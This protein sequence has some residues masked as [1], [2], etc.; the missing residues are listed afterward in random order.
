MSLSVRI[1]VC[2]VMISVMGKAANAQEVILTSK[3]KDAYLGVNGGVF[4][5]KP[6]VQSDLY[7]G[8]SNG[9][10]A[11]V[12]VSSGF[13]GDRDFDKEIDLTVGVNGS[14]AGIDYTIEA[15]Y[16]VLIVPD[17]FNIVVEGRKFLTIGHGVPIVPFLRLEGYAPF[18]DDGPR[19]GMMAI[20][21]ARCPV[22]IT[23]WLSGSLKAQ[24]RKD[25]GCFGNDPAVL[26]QGSL[27]FEARVSDD[28]NLLVGVTFSD[29]LT[30][31]SAADGRTSS[32]AL[33]GG[34]SYSF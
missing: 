23:P 20:I 1:L 15:S 9:V 26:A 25:T 14:A 7:L 13:N 11:D 33:T 10:Y 18:V 19:R 34:F 30:D 6:V 8:L 21:G 32:T 24:I 5:D 12:W 29:P 31:V 4:Y 28:L 16:F 17:V 3:V 27:D 2:V 22:Q